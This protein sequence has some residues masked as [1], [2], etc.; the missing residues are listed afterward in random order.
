[1]YNFQ[2]LHVFMKI[3][4][5]D[6]FYKHIIFDFDGV[7]AETN[8]IRFEGFR[9]LFKDYLQDQVE[10][11]VQYAKINGGMSRYE[12]IRYF[13]EQIRNEP[14]FDD[15]VQLLA[16]QYSELV[17]QKIIEA[18]PV[19]GSLEFLSLYHNSCDFA[20]V[21]GSDQEELIEI[22][23]ARRISHYFTEILGSPVSKE[24]N[25]SILFSKRGWR[26]NLS[27][28][29]GDSIND[30]NVARFHGIDFIGR[31]SGLTDWGL[32]SNVIFIRDL[33]QLHLHI[34]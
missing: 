28:F 7:L 26:K 13:F 5:H 6:K 25:C 30:L 17:K 22:C 19:N 4:S 33:S 9:L 32:I 15:K 20:I 34:V 29:V 2:E 27:V 11:L 16:R 1:M 31:D 12:K 23:Y 10:R 21:S 3:Q 24:V 14:V 18:D 8:T